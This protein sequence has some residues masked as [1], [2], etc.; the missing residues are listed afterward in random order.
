MANNIP[1]NILILK[2][3]FSDLVD[4]W[5]NLMEENK[6]QKFQEIIGL[7]GSPTPPSDLSGFENLDKS[8]QLYLLKDYVAELREKYETLFQQNKAR[9]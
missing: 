2:R 1:E 4:N 5:D 6:R 9:I 3:T 8:T 7:P